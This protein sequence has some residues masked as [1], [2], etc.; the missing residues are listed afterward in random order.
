MS[1]AMKIEN[2]YQPTSVPFARAVEL[3]REVEL[4]N[5]E[6][7]A[8]LDANLVEQWPDFF[9]ED[10]VYR[11]TAR[12]NAELN[13]PV[14]LVYAEGRAMMHDRA[15]AIARTQMFAP[16]Y[17]L[18]LVTNTRIVAEEGA[19]FR[20]HANFVLLQTLV[21]GPTTIHMAGSYHDVFVKLDGKLLLKERQA[22][23]DTTIIANDLVYPL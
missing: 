12:E 7:C 13:L 5:A 16:R 15:V 8:V 4:F 21:E 18:H 1:R 3:K 23:Y 20:A 9:T 22:I 11:V 17:S 10:A 6:Y 2:L 14:G 19:A